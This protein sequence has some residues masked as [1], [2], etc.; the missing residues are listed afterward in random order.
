MGAREV[1]AREAARLEQC[2]RELDE[3]SRA[4]DNDLIRRRV[5][6]YRQGL[7][8]TELTTV[9][10]RAA[11]RALEQPPQKRLIEE[12]LATWAQRD[13]FVEA[14]KNDFVVAY[15]WVKYNDLQRD[16]NPSERLKALVALR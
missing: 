16:F 7:R 10:V 5:E 12:A 1:L 4:A 6:F 14:L 15:F 2:H 9:A 3:A 11:R 8:Y 13:R